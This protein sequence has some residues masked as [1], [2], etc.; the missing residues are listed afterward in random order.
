MTQTVAKRRGISK[1]RRNRIFNEIAPLYSRG[2]SYRQIGERLGIS[3]A[4]VT[5]DVS[6]LK[7]HWQESVEEEARTAR[8]ELIAKHTAIFEDCREGYRAT[9]GAKFLELASKEL[10]CLARLLGQAG[11]A[12]NL[13]AHQH[14]HA[15]VDAAAVSELF[16]PLDA[17]TYAEMVAARVLP[18][19]ENPEEPPEIDTSSEPVQANWTTEN[20]DQHSDPGCVPVINADT[21]EPER[22]TKF[23]R[24]P[25]A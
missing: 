11:P 5:F 10:E 19:V 22:R 4:Q 16:K 21:Q 15:Q 17:G 2:L 12:I 24:H 6:V 1:A 20:Q 3:D 7:E 13:H 25:L 8:G 23:V 14:L 9:G 18:P